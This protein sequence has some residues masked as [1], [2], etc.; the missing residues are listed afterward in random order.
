MPDLYEKQWILGRVVSYNQ[1]VG[2]Y[3]VADADETED[4]IYSVPESQVILLDLQMNNS[5]KLTKGE[6]V[7]A[8]YPDTTSFYAATVTQAP[9]RTAGS[10][11]QQ[12]QVQ[13]HDD[14]DEFGTTPFRTVSLSR[15]IRAPT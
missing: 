1:E 9:R 7:L 8:V 4:K 14:A 11:G 3:Q 13:F 12:V 6:E 15:V 5:Q 2:Y 10:V